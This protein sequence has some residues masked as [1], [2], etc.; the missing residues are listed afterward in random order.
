MLINIQFRIGIEEKEMIWAGVRFLI[1]LWYS[2]VKFSSYKY[3]PFN[4]YHQ[5]VTNNQDGLILIALD[6]NPVFGA[7]GPR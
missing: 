5:T 4:E 2:F 6:I 7:A 1:F 3:Y